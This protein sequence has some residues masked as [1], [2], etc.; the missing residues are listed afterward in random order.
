MCSSANV[1]PEITKKEKRSDRKKE[2][3]DLIGTVWASS[4][5][6]MGELMEGRRRRGSN[7]LQVME[8]E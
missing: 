6:V 3:S 5:G 8:G 4:K 1:L 2:G 7:S